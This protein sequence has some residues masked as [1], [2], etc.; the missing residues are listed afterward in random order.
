MTRLLLAAAAGAVSSLAFFP[1]GLNAVLLVSL[2]PFYAATSGAGSRRGAFYAWVTGTLG[3]GIVFHWIVPLLVRFGGLSW[4]AAGAC[5]LL[6]L[7]W[8]GLYFAAVGAVLGMRCGSPMAGAVRVLW[9]VVLERFWPR[10]FPW[11]FGD[12]L[13]E[14]PLLCQTADL[15]GVYAVSALV[16]ACNH[17]L[18]APRRWRTLGATA[19][20]LLAALGYGKFRLSHLPAPD[21]VLDV[22]VLH[23]A[24]PLE[25]RHRAL[26]D[27]KLY[28]EHKRIL[29]GSAGG[30]A[31]L[32]V[33][34]EA[35]LLASLDGTAAGAAR[36]VGCPVLYGAHALGPG[37]RPHHNSA[38]LEG[39]GPVQLY[40][41][42]LLILFGERLPPGFGWL[43]RRTGRAP[44]DAGPGPGVLRLGGVGLGPL[45]CYEDVFPGYVRRTVLSGAQILVNVTEDGWF[46]W[47]GMPHQ[48]L[49]LSRLR[50]V[51]NRRALLR[52]VNN[53]ISAV[54]DP[55][56]RLLALE[57]RRTG[58]AL[59][60]VRVPAVSALTPYTRWGDWFV[61][62]GAGLCALS[63]ASALATRRR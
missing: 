51:E 2:A 22:V 50:A 36:G 26:K 9:P 37:G 41:K 5:L 15:G 3:C 17:A 29:F 35:S 56:G 44:I 24:I 52:S 49:L 4:A 7:L 14:F 21:A 10:I 60:R 19:L 23:P 63:L 6:F 57:S 11:H 38:V 62:L 20:L 59:L 58:A 47:T 25:E 16:L 55:A 42:S 33:M 12:P 8:E 18:A 61:Y 43:K 54:V 39:S 34:P 28:E 48:H 31:D 46:G 27:P 13:S 32:V 1:L 30:P 45:V 40:H 53:G